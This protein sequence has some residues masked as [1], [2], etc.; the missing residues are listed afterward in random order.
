MTPSQVDGYDMVNLDDAF[1]LELQSHRQTDANFTNILKTM[2]IEQGEEGNSTLTI[3]KYLSMIN[4]QLLTCNFIRSWLKVIEKGV[5][6]SLKLRLSSETYHSS[7][8]YNNTH[9]SL[10]Y[11][12]A[13]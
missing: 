8:L 11:F 7:N 13:S 3:V 2:E 6:L 12:M 5:S 10:L 9:T 4:L 1:E